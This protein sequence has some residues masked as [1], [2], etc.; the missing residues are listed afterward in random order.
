MSLP[1][2][3]RKSPIEA[4]IRSASRRR[5]G[6]LILEQLSYALTLVLSGAILLLLL[7]TQILDWYWLVLLAFCGLAAGYLRLRDRF[8]TRYQIAQTLDRRLQLSDT[9][10]TAWFLLSAP[11][12]SHPAKQIPLRQAEAFAGSVQLQTAF[13]FQGQRGWAISSLLFVVAFG[14]FGFRYLTQD[15]LAFRRSLIPLHVGDFVE[16]IEAKLQTRPQFPPK[17]NTLRA[18]TTPA[19][20]DD[21]PLSENGSDGNNRSVRSDGDKTPGQTA[22]SHTSQKFEDQARGQSQENNLEHQAQS[23]N[24]SSGKPAVPTPKDGQQHP[25]AKNG[26]QPNPNGQGKDQSLAS[27]MREA[28]SGLL[29]KMENG[30]RSS[31]SPEAN[32][33]PGPKA[34]NN[35]LASNRSRQALST[36]SAE[37]PGNAEKSALQGQQASGSERTAASQEQGSGDSSSHRPSDIHSAAGRQNGSK[38][39]RE[40]EELKAM[41]KLEEI[42]GKRSADVTG[43]MTVETSSNNQQLQTV[44]THKVARHF[45]LGSEIDHNEVPLDDQQYVRKYMMRIHQEPQA[46]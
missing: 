39:D 19:A 38:D 23:Q 4:L 27:R 12:D 41:G 7:G 33:P 5:H 44:D 35:R 6:L 2:D 1:N 34:G 28:L 13:P 18:Q 32:Q 43:E 21:I 11:S 36:N 29:E 42:I 25:P 20:M 16:Q 9:L 8:L 45:S 24:A 31:P 37:Q 17:P 10:S 15:Q 22:S 26:T 14:L 46:K 40:A 3:P 30:F